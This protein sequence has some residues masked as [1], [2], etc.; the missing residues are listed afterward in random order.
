MLIKCPECGNDISDKAKACPKCGWQVNFD[1]LPADALDSLGYVKVKLMID[2]RTFPKFHYPD[3]SIY[4]DGVE[5]WRGK[6]G[7]IAEIRLEGKT[8]V[9]VVTVGIPFVFKS[10]IFEGEIDPAKGTKYVLKLTRL[11]RNKMYFTPFPA[12]FF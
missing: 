10:G 12:D 4:I 7:D 5:V 1:E 9:K 2:K 8:K 6:A 3:S 11:F